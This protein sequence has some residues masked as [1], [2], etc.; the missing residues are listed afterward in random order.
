MEARVV[1][2]VPEITHVE[3]LILAHIGRAGDAV[4]DV[5]ME[6]LLLRVEGDTNIAFA[7][8]PVVPV[9]EAKLIVGPEAA[10]ERVTLPDEVP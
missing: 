9:L 6:P 5:M 2:G 1:V 7:T 4:Q 8:L 3:L 10:T